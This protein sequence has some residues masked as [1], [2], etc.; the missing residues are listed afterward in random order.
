M[1]SVALIGVLVVVLGGATLIYEGIVAA[2]RE[3][4]VD[5][6]P[7]DATTPADGIHGA[8][9]RHRPARVL[10]ELTGYAGRPV[11]P[12]LPVERARRGGRTVGHAG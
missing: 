4:V 9:R 5:V 8:G 2:T 7:P 6:S 11:A 12:L 1:R 3:S 10:V